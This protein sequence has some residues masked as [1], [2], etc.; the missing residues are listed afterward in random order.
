M[1]ERNE[2]A[3]KEIEAPL[4]RDTSLGIEQLNEEVISFISID[5][6]NQRD[7]A[8]KYGDLML[9]NLSRTIGLRLQEMLRSQFTKHKDCKLYYICGN[10]YYLLLKG[11]SLEQARAK[12]EVMRHT[13]GGDISIEQPALPN[14]VVLSDVTVRLGVASYTYTKLEENLV[15]DDTMEIVAE[16]KAKITH[17]LDMALKMGMD[18]GGNVVIAWNR[19][20]AGGAF[21]RWSPKNKAG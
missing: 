6:D 11:I 14:V 17:A 5:L 19:D 18:E 3:H 13:L 9:R 15:S 20:I 12:A 16:V 4:D 7:L 10:R 8:I 21:E 2:Q 1:L